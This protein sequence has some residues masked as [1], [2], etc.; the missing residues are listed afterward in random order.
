MAGLPSYLMG[1]TVKSE[2]NPINSKIEQQRTIGENPDLFQMRPM[3][4]YISTLDVYTSYDW[5]KNGFASNGMQNQLDITE[6]RCS[7]LHHS[8]IFYQKNCQA[9]VTIAHRFTPARIMNMVVHE[10]ISLWIDCI[11]IEESG[12]KNPVSSS[13]RVEYL[14]GRKYLNIISSIGS[15]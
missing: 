1:W 2:N 8:Q 3:S 11:L 9:R 13:Y 14:P 4:S 12:K 15:F 7:L 5:F 10:E 6:E